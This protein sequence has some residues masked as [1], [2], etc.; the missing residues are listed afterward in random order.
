MSCTCKLCGNKY[1]VDIIIP[2]HIWLDING[3]ADSGLICG[4]CIVDFLE[5]NGYGAFVLEPTTHWQ[6]PPKM[7]MRRNLI[8]MKIGDSI[9]SAKTECSWR[10]SAARCNC[11]V[12][13]KKLTDGKIR[14][15]KTEK[16]HYD[17]SYKKI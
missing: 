4:T 10:T 8:K 12:N 11:G 13:I 16:R 7:S 17:Q 9:I 3:E 5:S 15:T 2:D 14:V 1:K 6:L